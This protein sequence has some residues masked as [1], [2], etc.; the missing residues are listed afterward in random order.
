MDSIL[1]LLKSYTAEMKR[2]IVAAF[3]TSC[4]FTAGL[5]AELNSN[6]KLIG[7]SKA[8]EY[9]AYE[10]SG[11]DTVSARAFSLVQIV[12]V[13]KNDFVADDFLAEAENGRAELE[14]GTLSEAALRK[15]GAAI[16][17]YGII[18]G[19]QGALVYEQ[20]REG[21]AHEASFSISTG[22]ARQQYGVTLRASPEPQE[23]NYQTDFNTND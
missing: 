6:L 18:D 5:W 4:L 19:N 15:A 12:D 14:D 3:I 8:G 9:L 21:A 22:K 13:A 10:I 1:S 7:F 16:R 23:I 20:L 17:Q 11:Y 2:I